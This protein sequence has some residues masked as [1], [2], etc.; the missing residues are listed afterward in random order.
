MREIVHLQAGQCGNQIGAKR[1]H[2]AVWSLLRD[3][4]K[5]R[6]CAL[7]LLNQCAPLFELTHEEERREVIEGQAN[8]QGRDPP[9]QQPQQ[10]RADRALHAGRGARAS[11][12]AQ[13]RRR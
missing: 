13:L 7:F 12:V 4:L 3:A 6:S 10:R 9:A 8:A 11:L 1:R 2:E 5:H